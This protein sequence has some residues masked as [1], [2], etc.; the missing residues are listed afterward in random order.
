MACLYEYA[1]NN[2]AGAHV[3]PRLYISPVFENI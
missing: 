1:R 3:H 2:L